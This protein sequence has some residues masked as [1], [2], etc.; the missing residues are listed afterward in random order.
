[1][2]N[3]ALNFTTSGGTASFQVNN[4]G[5]L[6]AGASTTGLY[7]SSDST[8]TT[9]DVLLGNP[10]ASTP[11]LNPSASDA[12]NISFSL[13]APLTAG[14]YYL[15]VIADTSNVVMESG[16]TNNVSNAS[17]VIL[18]NDSA[19]TLTGNTWGNDTIFGFGGND[20]LTGGKGADLLIGGTGA[21]KFVCRATTDSM[22]S[23]P[24][25][26]ADFV[27]G[28]LVDLSVIDANTLVWSWGNQAFLY[29]GQNSAVVAN[30]VTWYESGGNTIIQADVNGNST[31]D[32]AII[33]TGTGHGLTA[34]D[35]IL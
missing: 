2:S 12:E 30:S 18:G 23:A 4:I 33:L 34:S 28:D 35:F 29:G 5:T 25:V 32:L 7:L 13:T 15:G 22:P 1:V 21:D 6:D 17:P 26:I 27:H 8:V 11:G 19:N 3:F 31:A 9:S 20:T 10:A 14:T 24:D 16:E